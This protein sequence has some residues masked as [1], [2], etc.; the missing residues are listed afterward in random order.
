MKKFHID[1]ISKIDGDVTHVW[2]YA[3][4]KEH[5]KNEVKHEYWDVQ[6]I[7]EIREGK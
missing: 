5:A 6:E 7:V 2:L 3:R 1:Y 4:S